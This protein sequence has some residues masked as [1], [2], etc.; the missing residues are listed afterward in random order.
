LV[1]GKTSTSDALGHPLDAP[2][3]IGRHHVS[4]LGRR[5]AFSK[6]AIGK[7]TG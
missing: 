4:S 5:G 6:A 7:Q 1:T 2:A 3:R